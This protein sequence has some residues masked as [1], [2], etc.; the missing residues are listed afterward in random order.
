MFLKLV[1]MM[2]ETMQID[3]KGMHCSACS[4]RIEK[5]ISKMDGVLK[6]NVNLATEKGR[7]IYDP[8]LT[9]K[10]LIFNRIKKIGYEAVISK[11][12]QNLIESKRREMRGLAW[13]FFIS[14]ILALPF[15]WTMFS[16]LNISFIPVPELFLNPWFQ[17][18]LATPVQFFIALPFYEGA[19]SAIKNR[20]ANMD[21]L[22]V[23]STSAAYFYS[24]YLTFSSSR[25]NGLHY[26]TSV[27][28]ITFV[29]LGKL[30]EA[31]SKRKTMDAIKKLNQL[32]VKS[33]IKYMNGKESKTFI[34]Q[35]IPGDIV[36]VKPGE[37]IPID[38]QVIEG[39]ST[40]NE[41]MLTGE[42]L[43]V[44]KNI[45]NTVY[46]GTMNENGLLKIKATKKENDSFL[47]KIIEIVEE[48]QI[49]KPPIQHIADKFTAIFVPIVV[50]IAVATFILWYG[51]LNPGQVN[52]ALEKTIAVL[53]ISCPCA[54]GLATPTSI[55][56]GSGKAAQI[57]IL[58]KEG[59][60][61]ELLSKN[62]MIVLD[63]TGTITKGNPVVTDI[64]IQ[65]IEENFFLQS[66]GALEMNTNHPIARAIVREAEKRT[67][68]LPKAMNVTTLPGHGVKGI[69]QSKE[70]IIANPSYFKT[71]TNHT[72]IGIEEKI[73][74]LEGQGKTVMLISIDDQ[75]VGIIAVADEV[76]NSSKR[77][78]QR[79]KQM[80]LKIMILS[81][82]NKN[83][84]KMIGEMVGIK[85]VEAEVTPEMKASWIKKLQNE[86]KKVIMVGDGIN[87]APA[88]TSANVGM[89]MGNGS[90]I[91]IESG[92]IT[93]LN[94]DLNKIADALIISK[95]TM[96]NIKQ[97]FI[98]AFI[99]NVISI[100]LAIIGVLP[101]WFASA[102]MAFSSV[103]VVL[104]SLRLK[105]IKF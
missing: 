81:G 93:I 8:N 61:I 75:L 4:A 92:D 57:G 14:A 46:S 83:S 28:I 7:I 101:P 91:A 10:L 73:N 35:I 41:S 74:K 47:S 20:S 66:V 87:D 23:L 105:N 56:V 17:L 52:E 53:I 67:D 44:E 103:S 99:Y 76:K 32:Q 33:A 34:H 45:G 97:N 60:L 26:E 12:A 90:D 48:A 5:V 43:P 24:H 100:P 16:H 96:R 79:L 69:V 98:W 68:N 13:K 104:N 31:K 94:N 82:D 25:T 30:M 72:L 63:K 89:A 62:N 9:S 1:K 51:Y 40:V 58:F 84:V 21:V 36:I 38:G 50:L 29:L 27:L 86:G 59:K 95:K 80:G 11:N 85:H 39:I 22:V 18:A 49:S 6:V 37:R 65:N 78:V 42:S 102:A 19:L 3:I 70:I 55:M 71:Q 88:L 2:N 15:I 54:L 64:F 77:A